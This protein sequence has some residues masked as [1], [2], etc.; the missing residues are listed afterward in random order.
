MKR[1]ALSFA[2]M[3]LAACTREEP[4]PRSAASHPPKEKSLEERLRALE[5]YVVEGTP[6]ERPE[7][8]SPKLIERAVQ[9]FQRRRPKARKQEPK[10]RFVSAGMAIVSISYALPGSA[11]PH[12]QEIHFFYDKGSW[13]MFWMPENVE[14]KASQPP[15]SAR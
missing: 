1:S 8:T 10:I 4:A 9:E 11:V 7:V 15:A 2:I 14:N 13:S 6:S 5:D 12:T 3:L